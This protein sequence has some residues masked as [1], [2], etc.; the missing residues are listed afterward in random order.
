M[1]NREGVASV[2]LFIEELGRAGGSGSWAGRQRQRGGFAGDAQGERD[3]GGEDGGD[4]AEGPGDGEFSAEGF[5]EPDH[6]EADEDEDDA[7]A[8]LEGPEF[9]HDAGEQEEQGAQS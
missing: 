8:V 4:D 5:V 1:L 2:F 9:M 3:G 6:L 7:E